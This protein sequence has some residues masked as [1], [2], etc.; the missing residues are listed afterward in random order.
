M[1]LKRMAL[2]RYKPIM[3][4]HSHFADPVS[5]FEAAVSALQRGDWH[6]VAALCDPD[7]LVAWRT[8]TAALLKGTSEPELTSEHCMRL[9]PDMPREVAE[10][11]VAQAREAAESGRRLWQLMPEHVQ[12][13]E[14]M[15]DADSATA[16]A[17]W[18]EFHSPRRQIER[19]I[20]LGQIGPDALGLV[21]PDAG[22][23]D[24]IALGFVR[25]GEDT[26]YVVY[27]ADFAPP[28]HAIA[29]PG[30]RR[31]VPATDVNSTEMYSMIQPSIATC[32]RQQD[33]CWRLVAT[34]DF[35]AVCRISIQAVGR[36]DHANDA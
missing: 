32:R 26:A 25:D 22:I 3:Q 14:T 13:L 2:D 29:L 17:A 11:H 33:D 10:S 12:L 28:A 15:R 19:L 36:D 23:Y 1:Q 20:V 27:R 21:P 16:F 18:L 24:Y 31:S 6:G 4:P 34:D 30:S 9:F 7:S 35:L 5:V 8:S